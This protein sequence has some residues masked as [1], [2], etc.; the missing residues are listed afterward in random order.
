MSA[1]SG[2]GGTSEGSSTR[3]TLLGGWTS[4]T[5]FGS[6]TVGT[7]LGKGTGGMSLGSG[8]GGTPGGTGRVVT[9][10]SGPASRFDLAAPPA[11]MVSVGTPEAPFAMTFQRRGARSDSMLI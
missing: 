8:K 7:A 11:V 2:T 4:G 1:G 5:S 9:A 10:S 3:G 6:C